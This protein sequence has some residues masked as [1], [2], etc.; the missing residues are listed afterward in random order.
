MGH[1]FIIVPDI[2]EGH[3]VTPESVRVAY[4]QSQIDDAMRV[5]SMKFPTL[6]LCVYKLCEIRK[7]KTKPTYDI[8][9][10]NDNGEV[11]PK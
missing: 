9:T 3:E 10:V 4:N 5:L 11:V 1:P 6:S 2:E 7:L 8:Y